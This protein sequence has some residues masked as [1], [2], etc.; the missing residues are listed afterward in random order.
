VIDLVVLKYTKAIEAYKDG[1]V[2]NEDKEFM[3]FV[4]Q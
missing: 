3:L 2:A 4:I 1:T